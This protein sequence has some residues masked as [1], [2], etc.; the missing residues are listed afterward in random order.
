MI[1]KFNIIILNEKVQWFKYQ[2]TQCFKLTPVGRL[3]KQ[4]IMVRRVVVEFCEVYIFMY[5]G[6]IESSFYQVGAYLQ[7]GFCMRIGFLTSQL[8]PRSTRWD[9]L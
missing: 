6:L 3:Y 8:D 7:D 2:K 9:L 4:E 1:L 5:N